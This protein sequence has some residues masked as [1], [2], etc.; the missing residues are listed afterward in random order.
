MFLE[1]CS[2]AFFSFN[3]HRKDMLQKGF[4]ALKRIRPQIELDPN[5]GV[6]SFSLSIS[7][8]NEGV[9][10][11]TV[12]DFF[13]FLGEEFSKDQIIVCFDEFQSV[14]NYPEADALLAKIRGKIQYHPF[15]YLFTGSDRN[16]LKTIFTRPDSPFYKSVRPMEVEILPTKDF[17]PFLLE[18]FAS[19]R[20]TVAPSVWDELFK[21]E[22]PGDIQQL[23]AALW[24]CSE[25]DTEIGSSVLQEAFDRIFTHEIEGFRSLLGGLTALQLRVL[26]SVAKTGTK[27]LYSLES[28]QAIGASASSIRR[29]VTALTEK[30]ILVN[31]DGAIYFNNPFLHHLLIHRQV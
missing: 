19:G 21:L 13:G 27:S 18:K 22:V 30:W 25:Q 14:L 23:C 15:P 5:T 29:S 20:R 6:P 26:K 24:E 3:H 10:L 8:K 2:N 12:D 17:K 11:N 28:Q 1:H 31:T 7:R 4:S 9:L 16:G